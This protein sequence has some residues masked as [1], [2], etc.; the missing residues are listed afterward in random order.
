FQST[1][2]TSIIEGVTY[3]SDLRLFT[4]HAHIPAVLFGPGDVRLA[5]A[6]NE[7]VEIEEVLL[8]IKIIANLIVDWCGETIEK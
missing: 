3:G 2:D 5:H 1:G 4:N 6:A 7:Y 8:T